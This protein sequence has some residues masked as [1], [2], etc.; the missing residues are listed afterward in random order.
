VAGEN[1]VGLAF[2]SRDRMVI[3]STNAI[4]RLN[5]VPN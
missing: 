5:R 1:L 2:D 4:Y 3:A